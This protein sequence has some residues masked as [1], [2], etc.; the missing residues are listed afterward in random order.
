[1]MHV[2]TIG[3][4][5]VFDLAF[6]ATHITNMNSNLYNNKKVMFDEI[7]FSE[8]M[9]IV[10][11]LINIFNKELFKKKIYFINHDRKILFLRI[12]YISNIS[13]IM[14]RVY[15]YY[16]IKFNE[17]GIKSTYMKVETL[18]ILLVQDRIKF[19]QVPTLSR[20]IY[21]YLS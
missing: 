3:N 5:V 7:T 2:I 16:L 14:I 19:Q 15:D 18:K 20:I 21:Y 8:R 1:M 12:Y 9:T 6:G 13:A 11:I 17:M 10:L 4:N